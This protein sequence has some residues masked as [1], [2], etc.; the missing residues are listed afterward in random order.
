MTGEFYR[1]KNDTATITFYLY[2]KIS[3][4]LTGQSIFIT[5]N[6]T[7]TTTSTFPSAGKLFQLSRMESI[8]EEVQ[9]NFL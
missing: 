2:W 1:P 5:E 4:I 9:F 6:D 8:T 3:I 7:G